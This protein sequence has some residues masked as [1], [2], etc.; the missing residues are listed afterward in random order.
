LLHSGVSALMDMVYNRGNCTVLVMD[1]TTT[2]MTGLQGHPGN[3]KTAAGEVG[4]GVNLEKLIEALGVEW[5]RVINPYDI[6]ESEAT[7][8]EA[9]D[10]CGP[11][12]VI[13]RAPCLLLK[14]KKPTQQAHLSPDAC[15]GCGECF[16]VGCVAI[17]GQQINGFVAPKINYDLCIGCTLCVQ[18]CPEGALA[19]R[20]VEV[21]ESAVGLNILPDST[22][23]GSVHL[24]DNSSWTPHPTTH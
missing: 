7:L 10:Y 3:G 2:A 15:T 4:N 6:N 11:S 1:N 23:T 18:S 14:S 17:D 12:V 22:P 24:L 13:S 21:V 9:L 20:Q 19:P 8:R 16:K 5:I